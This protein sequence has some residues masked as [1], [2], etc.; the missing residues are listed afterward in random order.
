MLHFLF[1]FPFTTNI[2]KCEKYCFDGKFI[3]QSP[4]KEIKDGNEHRKRRPEDDKS[5]DSQHSPSKKPY[6]S[7][8]SKY[9][10]LVLYLSRIILFSKK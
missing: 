1:S 8:Q 7:S 5:G 3:F 9:V 10:F 2:L 4:Q 6:L